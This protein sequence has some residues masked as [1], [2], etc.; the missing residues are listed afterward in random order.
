MITVYH[1]SEHRGT[2]YIIYAVGEDQWLGDGYYFWQDF[3]F[4]REWG[5]IKNI[6]HLIFMLLKLI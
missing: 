4:A 2:E 3:E 1:T 6:H 5:A